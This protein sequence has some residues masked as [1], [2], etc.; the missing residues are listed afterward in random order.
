VG[1]SRES[2]SIVGVNNVQRIRSTEDEMNSMSIFVCIC[3][4]SNLSWASLAHV[5]IPCSGSAQTCAAL[6]PLYV[7]NIGPRVQIRHWK[8][9]T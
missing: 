2:V 4:D 6:D 8:L 5:F 9:Y 1:R 3:Y 7:M